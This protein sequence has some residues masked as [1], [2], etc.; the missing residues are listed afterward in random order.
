MTGV[1]EAAAQP[2]LP[3]P[4]RGFL[5][6]SDGSLLLGSEA[7][8]GR[9]PRVAVSFRDR[10]ALRAHESPQGIRSDTIGV[11]LVSADQPATLVPMPGW[12]PLR[13]IRARAAAGGCMTVL[14]FARPLDVG[15]V[16]AE[17]GRQSVWPDRVGNR[18][19]RVWRGSGEPP[20][21]V[22]PDLVAESPPDGSGPS[23]VTGRVPLV[24]ADLTGPLALGPLDERVLNPIGFEASAT[25]PVVD[26]SS[27]DL[28][29]GPTE[30]LVSA[31][32]E[33]SG[34]TVSSWDAA[35]TRV[36][37]GLAM[38]GVP[39]TGVAP[40]EAAELLGATVTEALAQSVELADDLAREEHSL[41]L[42]RAALETFSSYAWRRG[43]GAR[44]GVQV[45][46]HPAV[47][48]VLATRRP[49]QLDFALQQVARQRG[50]DSL[51]LVLAPHGFEADAAR[52]AEL[53]G[54]HVA[55]Q[56]VG[57][58]ETTLFGDV[59]A[60]AA[61]A[62]TGDVVLKMDDDDWYAPDVV[63]DLLRARAYSGAELVGM[64]AEFHYLAE[65]DLTV[66][67]GH[68]SEFYARFVAGGTM[69]IDRD[70]LREVG[71]FRPVR[72]YVDAQLLA[73]VFA[74]GAA[75]YRT[76]GLGYVLRRN[77]SGHTWEVDMDY[78]LD[79]TRV[80]ATWPGFTPSRLLEL[81]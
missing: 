79:P 14:R 6:R 10:A 29:A 62:A 46:V 50:V 75:V 47:S 4:V 56:V 17:L 66:K 73:G 16:L 26:L 20:T 23:E 72:K 80:A 3:A 25:Q 54:D 15:V 77:A 35:A 61:G 18:G 38:A 65:P 68:P 43:A 39:V 57:Q 44:A 31:V 58:P 42:R 78:L 34:V 51:E 36:V 81:P 49:E 70:L 22:P 9:Y 74:A 13:G 48:I 69:M 45:A 5:D 60:A 71:S 32:R 30:A 67:R 40:P 53:L 41:V 55:L 27:L 33:H 76:H 64:P 19:L 11:F 7:V 52:V 1:P 63:A 37:A 59:L 12:P 21:D 24:I 28:R 2:E 8:A